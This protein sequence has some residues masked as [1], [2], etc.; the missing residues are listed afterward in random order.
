MTPL[1]I[2]SDTHACL[3]MRGAFG[4]LVCDPWIL[5][6]PVANYVCWKF[7]AAVIPPEEV[8]RDVD[9]VYL[10]HCHEDHFHAPSMDRFDRDVTVLIPALEWHPS[11]RAQTMEIVLRRM[12]FTDI[13]KL[14]GWQ[15]IDLG[16][17]TPFTVIPAARSRWY[18]WE[19]SGFL[20]DHHDGLVLNMNDNV[21]DEELCRQIVSFAGRRID[22]GFVQS[23]GCSMHP[24]CFRMSEEEM[25]AEV[26]RRRVSMA[27]QRRMIELIGPRWI[28][29]MA[30]DFAWYDEKYFHNN[31]ASRATPKL[32]RETVERDYAGRDLQVAVMYPTDTWTPA[33]GLTRNHPE[34]D[35]D[36]YLTAMR[37]EQRRFQPK[38]DAINA[39]IDGA[40]RTDLE[41]RSHDFTAFVEKHVTR[42][43]IDFT[44]RFRH[45]VE[46]P[47][48]GFS[49]TLTASPEAGFAIA[50]DDDGPV[51][52][53]L[54]VPER[55]WAA[56]LDGRLLWTEI[57][58]N[59]EAEQHVE[60]R[61]DIARFWYWLEY[62]VSLNTKVTQAYV[63]PFLNPHL[64][65]LDAGR[66][67]FP[68]AADHPLAAAAE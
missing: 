66:G 10:T 55:I 47:N 36:D 19:N 39:Y 31:W 52:Q 12:G 38:I 4:T 13:R 6:E 21:S 56:I 25:R 5:N 2:E 15:T 27:D 34:I 22:I 23:I 26:Q 8:T 44:A 16:G 60:F 11:L 64:A 50:W 57:Q 1:S 59:G 65:R 63:E 40:D 14:K 54:Y 30:G 67:V 32:F 29:P 37:R 3:R 62:Y 68:T 9:Y 43:H 61:Y 7:P 28:A 46:G 20:L 33:D 35:W 58:W 18:D 53:T 51:D 45:V 24:G 48:A 41:R 42:D 49:F 17:G